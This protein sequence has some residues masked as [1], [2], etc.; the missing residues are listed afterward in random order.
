MHCCAFKVEREIPKLNN[1]KPC[2][3][4]TLEPQ[5]DKTK[6][7]QEK[8]S[9][10]FNGQIAENSTLGGFGDILNNVFGEI[11]D[12]FNTEPQN[13]SLCSGLGELVGGKPF[14]THI[15][16][17]C[18][19]EP[20]AFNPCQDVMGSNEL[21]GFSWI[22]AVCA[23]IGNVFQLVILFYSKQELTV[24][25]LLMYN[26]GVSNL[27]MGIYLIVLC[28]VDAYTFGKYYN[29]VQSWQFKGGC[30]VFGF[31]ALFATSLSVCNLVLITLER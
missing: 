30:Q 26:L 4:E 19:P 28:C 5:N 6:R 3:T 24:Y 20:D 21:R 22:I 1:T 18:T 11:F 15:K 12:A 8:N 13:Y 25:K 10:G 31:L 7:S 14:D 23:I 2:P 9:T 17:E 27:L 16:I 29:Y